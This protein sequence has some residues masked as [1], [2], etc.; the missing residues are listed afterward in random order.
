MG[1]LGLTLFCKR[2]GR[3]QGEGRVQLGR[4]GTLRGTGKQLNP[5]IE[6]FDRGSYCKEIGWLELNASQGSYQI[7]S[8]AG[9]VQGSAVWASHQESA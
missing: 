6:Y 8:R 2:R 3:Q 5:S 4:P 9:F 1:S 7:G